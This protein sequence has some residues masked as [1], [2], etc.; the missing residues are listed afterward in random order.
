MPEDWLWT[1]LTGAV[2]VSIVTAKEWNEFTERINSFREYHGLSRNKF[3]AAVAGQPMTTSQMNQ[4]R[5]AIA[6]MNPTI[7]V[8]PEVKSNTQTS[9]A[10][11][12][13]YKKF[14]DDI[15]ESLNSLN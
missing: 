11:I 2:K 7:A 6:E 1:T 4:A 15:T 10:F 8:P 14:I 3:N 9:I 12:T 13:I 5:A